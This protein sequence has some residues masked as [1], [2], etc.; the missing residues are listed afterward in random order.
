VGSTVLLFSN[1]FNVIQ[2]RRVRRAGR[3]ARMEEF[4]LVNNS[5]DKSEKA[6]GRPRK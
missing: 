3:V 2:P 5:C 1:I 4:I 6:L